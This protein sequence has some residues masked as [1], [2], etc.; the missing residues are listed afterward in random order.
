MIVC[1]DYN[2][3]DALT[4]VHRSI[5]DGILIINSKEFLVELKTFDDFDGIKQEN[6]KTITLVKH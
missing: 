4:K 6:V 2:S 5:Y 3:P 1:F